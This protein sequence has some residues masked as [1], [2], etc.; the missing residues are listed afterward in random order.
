MPRLLLLLPLPEPQRPT[1][2][3]R[4]KNHQYHINHNRRPPRNTPPQLPIPAI[5]IRPSTLLLQLSQRRLQL[6]Q[7]LQL[8]LVLTE[9]V[10]EFLVGVQAFVGAGGGVGERSEIRDGGC[11][12]VGYRCG[13]RRRFG[14]FG[15]RGV[16][17]GM[18]VDCSWLEL[19]EWM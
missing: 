19:Q 10:C 13:I 7:L 4:P 6:L 2:N 12:G 5:V 9:Q 14:R 1:S 8:H 17:W 16:L 11:V 18:L 15:G 3:S